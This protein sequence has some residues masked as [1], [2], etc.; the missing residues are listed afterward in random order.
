MRSGRMSDG[1]TGAWG[2]TLSATITG[3]INYSLM[4]TLTA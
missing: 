1:T 4:M 3:H 2:E